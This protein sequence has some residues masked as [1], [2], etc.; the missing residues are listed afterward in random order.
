M[1]LQRLF[2]ARK[3]AMYIAVVINSFAK[4]DLQITAGDMWICM[5]TLTVYIVFLLI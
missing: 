1:H 5:S 3:S 2:S 4:N